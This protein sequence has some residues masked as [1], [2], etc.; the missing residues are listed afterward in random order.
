MC[1]KLDPTTSRGRTS[2]TPNE[3]NIELSCFFLFDLILK[4]VLKET[5]FLISTYEVVLLRTV[6]LQWHF[7]E[8]LRPHSRRRN[9]ES[10]L[11]SGDILP[12][13]TISKASDS[14][15]LLYA[16]AKICYIGN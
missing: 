6:L 12:L 9:I 13:N 11:F 4:V 5:C 16:Q 14:K 2:L 8:K 15:S 3:L 1:G 7:S 10:A